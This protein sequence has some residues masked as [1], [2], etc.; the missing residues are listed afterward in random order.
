M[1][2]M[3]LGGR[4]EPYVGLRPYDVGDRDRFFGRGREAAEV[5]RLWLGSRLLVLHGTPG[6]GKTSLLRAGLLPLVEPVADVLPVARLPH[7][8]ALTAADQ[9]EHNP[10]TFAL[11][12]SWLPDESPVRL[13]G[14]SVPGLLRDREPRLDEYGEPVETL[15]AID[16]FEELFADL[17]YSER[18]RDEFA[19]V[20]AAALAELPRL[21]LLVS[22]R[23]DQLAA[24]LPYEGLL[25][26]DDRSRFRLLPLE[27]AAAMDAVQ[28]P[29]EG[30]G[31]FFDPAAAERLVQD[32]RTVRITDRLGRTSEVLGARVEPVQ[33]QVVCS[34][35]WRNLPVQVREITDEHRHDH[36]DID[37]I[38]ADFC[39]QAIVEVAEQ[40]EQ[41]ATDLGEWLERAFVTELGTRGTAY[42][43]LTATAGVPN[44]VP[45]AF[46]DRRI[47]A[48]ELRSGSR[49]YELQHDRW[50]VPIRLVNRPWPDQQLH[51]ETG[52]SAYLR[53]AESALA[54]GDVT[55]AE[56]HAEEALRVAAGRDARVE[57]E[58]QSFLGDLAA[59]RGRVADALDRY[60]A[61][62]ALL[63]ALPDRAAAGRLFAAV[64]TLLRQQGRVPEAVVEWQRAMER[65]PGDADVQVMLAAGLFHLQQ[66]TAAVGLYTAVLA[67]SPDHPAALAGRGQLFADSGRAAAA[68]ED[69]DRLVQLHPEW[70][71]RAEVRS[72]RGLALAEAGR[73]AEGAAESSAAETED[74]D[75]GPVLLRAAT[76][77]R[78]AGD[79]ARAA[80]LARR[81][82]RATTPAL[83][84]HRAA[85][86]RALLAQP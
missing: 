81:A 59:Q 22:I 57:A 86:A 48:S 55:L 70:A 5:K 20:L 75:N 7:R 35:L 11:L 8:G 85:A 14:R 41:N 16:Q 79:R 23:E 9:L 73:V 58:A 24:L 4:P 28:R 67:V 52:A 80:D 83:P 33:L 49:W 60:R 32:L 50:I 38:L 2:A 17:P 72:A 6:V 30:T 19:G 62:A 18:Y 39:R 37:R 76:V 45:H 53:A 36:A 10:F 51:G 65:L 46:E 47:L 15:V 69:L 66:P 78:L 82:L 56:K 64:G 1:F 26:G 40:T 54:D 27:P 29:L 21:R 74:P 34:A 68:L 84:P 43:G 71:G 31:R 61:G 25:A 42:E 13:T 3:T 44:A 77:A 63:E 12:S